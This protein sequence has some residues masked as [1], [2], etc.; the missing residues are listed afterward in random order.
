MRKWNHP[1]GVMGTVHLARMFFYVPEELS[2]WRISKIL[3][4]DGIEVSK[5]VNIIGRSYEM[6]KGEKIANVH[7]EVQRNL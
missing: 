3:M 6:E 2:P 4:A 1:H 7:G 5:T